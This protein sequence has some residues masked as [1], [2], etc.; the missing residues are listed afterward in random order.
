MSVERVFSYR[1]CWLLPEAISDPAMAAYTSLQSACPSGRWLD[2]SFWSNFAELYPDEAR[3]LVDRAETVLAGR[4][5]LF[6]WKQLEL[7]KPPC[8][9]NALTQNQPEDVWPDIYYGDLAFGHDPRHPERDVRWC[10]ELNRFQHLLWLGAAWRLTADERFAG[11]ARSHIESWVE[12]QRYPWGVHWASN[13]EVGLRALSWMR[14][15]ILCCSSGEW[16]SRFVN[17]L[18][19]C[20]YLHAAHLE[21]ELSLHHPPGNHL[22]GETA[23]LFCLSLAYPFFTDSSRWR[24]NAVSV[25]NRLVPQ[26]IHP[27]GVYAE[28][29]T[30]YFR[31]V[32]EFLFPVLDLARQHGIP[33]SP[34]I[35]ER[36]HAGLQWMASLSPR[37]TEVPMIGDADTGAAIGWRLSDYW[38]FTPLMALGAVQGNRPE[39]ATGIHAFPAESYLMLGGEARNAFRELAGECQREGAHEPPFELRHFP[40]GGYQVSQSPGFFVV[41]DV[42]PLGLAPAY[43]HGHADGLSFILYHRGCPVL[44]DPGTGLYNGPPEWRGYFPSAAA[45]NTMTVAGAS[46]VERLDTFRWSAP[47]QIEAKPPLKGSRWHLLQ[48]SIQWGGLVHIRTLLHVAD[49]GLIILDRV[50]GK[51]KHDLEFRFHFDPQWDLGH[52]TERHLVAVSSSDGLDFVFHTPSPMTPTIMK[53]AEAPMAGWVSPYYGCRIPSPTVI[54]AQRTRLPTHM[55][56]IIK[57]YDS[58]IHIPGGVPNDRIPK[59]LLPPSLH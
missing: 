59:E 13:L 51:G 19:S 57:P 49:E 27:D 12:V 39:L 1:R 26:L 21:K 31:F 20:L 16:E 17:R 2:P 25:L 10:W 8:W 48:G 50:E 55:V 53:G 4:F 15:H 56:T 30:G 40:H 41:F 36:L 24:T 35:S 28:Q 44:V 18:L 11:A 47:L 54:V 34:L 45:H 32:C 46:P 5:Q 7:T 33:L 52:A 43:A 14:C 42:G 23:A 29:T 9:S 58:R 6:Q 3:Q 22:L 37:G 38:D